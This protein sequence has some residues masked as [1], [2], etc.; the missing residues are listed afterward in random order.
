MKPFLYVTTVVLVITAGLHIY[1]RQYDDGL[2]CFVLALMIPIL[3]FLLV[4][5]RKTKRN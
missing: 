3:N 4:R 2:T 1:T 5:L